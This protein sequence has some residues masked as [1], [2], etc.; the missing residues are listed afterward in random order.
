[1]KLY[2][3]YDDEIVGTVDLAKTVP[4]LDLRVIVMGPVYESDLAQREPLYVHVLSTFMPRK[5]RQLSY[6]VMTASR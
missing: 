2:F 5:N 1:M 6:V 3:V 4:E